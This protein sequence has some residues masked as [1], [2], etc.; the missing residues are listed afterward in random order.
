MNLFLKRFVIQ[1]YIGVL[2]SSLITFEHS[3]FDFWGGG[4]IRDGK[5]KKEKKMKKKKENKTPI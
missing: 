5:E 2:F 1:P 3:L 4:T